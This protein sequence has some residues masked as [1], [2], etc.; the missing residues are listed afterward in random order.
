MKRV[1]III[2]HYGSTSNT[3]ACLASIKKLKREHYTPLL[4][5]VD[6]GSKEKLKT[7]DI[8]FNIGKVATIHNEENLGF[9]GGNN[10][11]I[12]YALE[13]G[14]D[15]VLL[16]NNDTLVDQHLVASLLESAESNSEVGIIAPKIYFAAGY[17]FYKERYSEKD[18]GKVIWYAGGIINWKNVVGRH[19]GVDEMDE[20]QYKKEEDTDFASGCC[21]FVKREVYEKIGLLDEKYFLYYEDSDFS[22]RAK[23]GGFKIVF[24]P[25][26]MLWHKNAG[27]AGGSGSSLQDYYITRNR[28]LFGMRY[29][30]IRSKIALMRESARLFLSGREWQKRGVIDFYRR[31][32]GKGSYPL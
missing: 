28:L 8:K 5:I 27:A 1:A 31:K 16:L 30:P 11:G 10:I 17:E 7:K 2:L 15:F 19:R 3:L 25:G 29:A 22:L 23:R 32:F 24:A 18:R 13:Q 21:M 14:A 4:I 12:R 20:G 9:T 6:N 26:A